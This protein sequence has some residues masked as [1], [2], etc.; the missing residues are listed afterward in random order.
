MHILNVPLQASQRGE[1]LVARIAPEVLATHSRPGCRCIVVVVVV[2][3]HRGRG[4]GSGSHRLLQTAKGESGGIGSF[5][6]KSIMGRVGWTCG[7]HKWKLVY[8]WC[9]VARL[10]S[11]I[12]GGWLV[13]GDR[14][15][16]KDNNKQR[17]R[18]ECRSN[19]QVN[20]QVNNAK[21]VFVCRS[22]SVNFV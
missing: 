20:T 18:D 17:M 1:V 21:C 10:R 14:G 3:A 6:G 16:T 2:T 9:V 22:A 4:R 12:V 13:D 11:E 5:F 15:A 19:S 8:W 7:Q